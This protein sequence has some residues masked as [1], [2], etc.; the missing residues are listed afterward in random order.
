M[1]KLLDEAQQAIE[2]HYSSIDYMHPDTKAT[3]DKYVSLQEELRAAEARFAS[4]G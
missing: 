1:G 2:A 4:L 3:Y